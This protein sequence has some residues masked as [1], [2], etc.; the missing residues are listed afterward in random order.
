MIPA[1][2]TTPSH[3]TLTLDRAILE[4]QGAGHLRQMR[5]AIWLYLELLSLLPEGASTISVLPSNIA[6]RMGLKEG[7]IRS[8]L[9]HLRTAGYLAVRG[10][11]SPLEI[12]IRRLREIGP[13]TPPRF[14]TVAK[15]EQ[16]LDETG[17]RGVLEAALA[18][19]AD[20]VIRRALAGALAVPAGD[21]K[22]SRTALFL[23]LAKRYAQAA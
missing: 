19:H 7:T 14:F 15:L 6:A 4:S 5:I 1:M 2:P 18:A 21:I 11:S 23:Y 22:K 17:Q 3:L 20:D 9:G 12:T 13:A 10:K 16:A 8:W